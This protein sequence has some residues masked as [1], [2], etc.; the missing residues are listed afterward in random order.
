MLWSFS[1]GFVSDTAH[2]LRCCSPASA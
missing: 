1:F 2:S